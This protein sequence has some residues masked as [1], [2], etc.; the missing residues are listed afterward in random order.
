MASGL[1]YL[2]SSLLL[3]HLIDKNGFI[4]HADSIEHLI[5]SPL[6]EIEIHRTLER[7]YL[8]RKLAI[9]DYSQVIGDAR[10]LFESITMISLTKEIFDRAK[11]SFPT[12]IKT[13]DSIHMS[14]ILWL[15]KNQNKDVTLCTL[16]RQ[17]T[18][19]AKALGFCVETEFA[20]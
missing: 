8:E 20:T 14:C 13:L 18:N 15:Q 7:L 19:C 5:C 16:D 1:F 10:L 4:L 17:Q 3:G 6:V 2:D 11:E 12:P 9:E